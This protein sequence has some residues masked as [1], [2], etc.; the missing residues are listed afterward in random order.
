M[1]LSGLGAF[2]YDS[3]GNY[4]GDTA[5]APLTQAQ[6]H[7]PIV[8]VFPDGSKRTIPAYT[9]PAFYTLG[10][11]ENGVFTYY[12]ENLQPLPMGFL[13]PP[14]SWI[15]PPGTQFYNASTGAYAGQV[16]VNSDSWY[17]GIDWKMA[18]V[19]AVAALAP[20]AMT[21]MGVGGGSTI[22]A[23][24]GLA[25]MGAMGVDSAVT[26]GGTGAAVG[27]SWTA[28][29]VVAAMQSAPIASAGASI[30]DTGTALSDA[31][32][33]QAFTTPSLTAVSPDVALANAADPA[34][35]L[36]DNA[37]A[38]AANNPITFTAATPSLVDTAKNVYDIGKQA[39][40]VGG[41]IKAGAG[42]V[43]AALGVGGAHAGAPGPMSVPGAGLT[44]PTIYGNV[45]QDGTLPSLS[46]QAG[47][48]L[49]IAALLGVILILKG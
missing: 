32:Q 8:A 10:S 43:A 4:V 12:D 42:M 41:Q 31:S 17:S 39:L 35:V 1:M 30:V 48:L 47:L 46:Q 5:N 26:F 33:V 37:S 29:G 13:N 28:G 15:A 2:I 16:N 25:D 3:Q 9:T 7:P 40:N 18:A 38:L 21:A 27:T 6:A 19:V 45:P 22:A 36:I 44:T 11:G 20:Y 49:P 14:V 34:N 24:G 23:S